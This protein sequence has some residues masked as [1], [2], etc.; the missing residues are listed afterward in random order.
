MQVSTSSSLTYL[1]QKIGESFEKSDVFRGI[2]Q[3]RA[4]FIYRINKK[5]APSNY[6]K[7]HSI[8]QQQHHHL[9]INDHKQ[10]EHH[11][12]RHA[13]F[14]HAFSLTNKLTHS[15]GAATRKQN[16]NVHDLEF[17]DKRF[18]KIGDENI[19]EGTSLV[20][21]YLRDGDELIVILTSEDIWLSLDIDCHI[22]GLGF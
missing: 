1:K 14:Q 16:T 10:H 18:Q 2:R 3:L 11:L 6:H 20:N 19:D 17:N 22:Q 13:S 21:D 8:K 7:Q 4:K 12:A 15:G 5:G 9:H